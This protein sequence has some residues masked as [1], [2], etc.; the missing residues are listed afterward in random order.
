MCAMCPSRRGGSAMIPT[1]GRWYLEL[2]TCRDTAAWVR[3]TGTTD[4]EQYEEASNIV[5]G[6]IQVGD[7]TS[8]AW[9]GGRIRAEAETVRGG[10]IVARVSYNGKVWG[11]EPWQAGVV[12]LYDPYATAGR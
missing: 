8:S 6:Y 11:P 5:R 12:P 3:L 9:T 7:M 10:R 4:A 1:P 2:R